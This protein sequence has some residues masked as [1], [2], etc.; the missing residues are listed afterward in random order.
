MR[1]VVVA[2]VV[3]GDAVHLLLLEEGVEGQQV[4]MYI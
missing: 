3:V 1:G 4:I 2:G